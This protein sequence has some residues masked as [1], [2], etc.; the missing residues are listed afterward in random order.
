MIHP[1]DKPLD[2]GAF[3][4]PAD[5][6]EEVR[7]R[8]FRVDQ[9]ILETHENYEAE[10]PDWKRGVLVRL[11]AEALE[12]LRDLCEEGDVDTVGYHSPEIEVLRPVE[13]D[14]QNDRIAAVRLSDD[15]LHKPEVLLAAFVARC[16][17]LALSEA[18]GE[19]AVAEHQGETTPS[20][21]PDAVRALLEQM[22]DEVRNRLAEEAMRR[23]FQVGRLLDPVYLDPETGASIPSQ[24]ILRLEEALSAIPELTV[25]RTTA[26]DSPCV[27]VVFAVYPVVYRPWSNAEPRAYFPIQVSLNLG[28]D[29]PP[30]GE[31]DPEEREDW[32]NRLLEGLREVS[33]RL[34]GS[35]SYREPTSKPAPPP[36]ERRSN[37]DPVPM[38][39]QAAKD[40]GAYSLTRGLGPMFTGLRKI[41]NLDLDNE[42]ACAEADRL[43]WEIAAAHLD[44]AVAAGRL[45]SWTKPTGSPGELVLHGTDERGAR[46]RWRE[47]HEATLKGKGGPGLKVAEPGFKLNSRYENGADIVE[48]RVVL[49]PEEALVLKTDGRRVAPVRFHSEAAPGY[50]ALLERHGS[51]PFRADGWVWIPRGE[52]REGF[53]IGG[54]EELLFPEG[55]DAIEKIAKA[56]ADHYERHLEDIFANPTLFRD[57]DDRA[58]Q[59][60]EAAIRRARAW[61]DKISVYNI[62]PDLYQCIY[63]AFHRQRDDWFHE[64]VRLPDGRVVETRPTRVLCLDPAALRLRLDPRGSWGRNWR[65]RLGDQLEALTTLRRETRTRD[66][67]KV[68]VGDQFLRR[69]VDGRNAP[70]EP[71]EAGGSL[72]GALARAVALPSDLFFVEVS[73]DFMG[74]FYTWTT[75]EKGAVHWGLDAARVTKRLAEARGDSPAE[76]REK[77]REV[78]EQAKARPYFDHSVRLQSFGNAQEWPTTRKRLAQ[79][80][81]EEATPNRKTYRDRQGNTQ[82][83]HAENRLG[84]KRSLA[85]RDGRDFIVCAGS[86]GRGYTVEG[87]LKKVEYPRRR[88]KGGSQ[89]ALKAFA[90]DLEALSSEIELRVEADGHVGAEVISTLRALTRNAATALPLRLSLL[91]PANL[92]EMLEDRLRAFGILDG[93]GSD[94]VPRSL[95]SQG[96]LAPVDIVKA[97]MKAGI[98]QGELAARIGVSRV[99][100]T[101][102]ERGT[103][104]IPRDRQ[105]TLRAFIDE[106]DGKPP[107]PAG[108]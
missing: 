11:L 33:I 44:G 38:P 75:D 40:A 16:N 91:I 14:I 25:P 83:R 81:L 7:A 45:S 102:W 69:V 22:P 48:T 63:E 101:T 13:W 12:F 70:A 32:W 29:V 76:V 100:L 3:A 78:S 95:R 60:L 30:L 55:R 50:V 77:T 42:V 19:L 106:V 49:W 64:R 57:E 59:G 23:P 20:K 1:P 5:L 17:V 99:A 72:V 28:P 39:R 108:V 54:L 53:R 96:L 73:V 88:G 26:P 8:R 62:G 34:S 90:E 107:G 87:W 74:A 89:G 27:G 85:Q 93:S 67:K 79:A 10:Y 36:P 92:E 41:P 84:G 47:I 24:E 58:S 105:E 6:L 61:V 80:L 86:K 2:L 35:Q 71:N 15:A 56:D 104:P 66:G 18:T 4:S 82:S 98:T 46:T 51:K 9:A 97:R 94:H 21:M 103:K 37:M 68:E 31:W 65:A 52:V 43:F